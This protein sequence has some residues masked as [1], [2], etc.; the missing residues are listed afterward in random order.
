MSEFR[1]HN[2]NDCVKIAIETDFPAQRSRVP[3]ECSPPETVT[4]HDAVNEPRLLIVWGIQAT[5]LGSRRQHPEIIRARRKQLDALRMVAAGK[6]CIRGPHRREIFEN[7]RFVA[8][9]P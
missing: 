4:E 1:G 8:Q 6:I 7:I 5:E 9:I 2:P 3:S